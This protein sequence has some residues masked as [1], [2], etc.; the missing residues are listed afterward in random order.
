MSNSEGDGA[1]AVVVDRSRVLFIDAVRP[2]IG[3]NL[4]ELP[5]GQADTADGSPEATAARELLE[6][7]GLIANESRLL[8]QIWAESGLSGDAV[9]VVLV[10]VDPRAERVDAE[11]STLRWIDI[12]RIGQEIADSKIGDGIS[13]SAL[14]LAWA[15][16]EL[17]AADSFQGESE[18]QR[19]K[20]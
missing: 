10:R 19:R 16:G 15:K 2:A 12:G 8:G 18:A 20:N 11:Y 5:R 3:R 4:W 9:N 7:T 14:A 13:I 6:E 1:V 17:N